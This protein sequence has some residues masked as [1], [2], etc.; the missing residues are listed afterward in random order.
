MDNTLLGS[1]DYIITYSHTAVKVNT[2]LFL[3]ICRQPFVRQNQA[4]NMN[5]S[6][7]RLQVHITGRLYFAMTVQQDIHALRAGRVIFRLG[8]HC[9]V[10]A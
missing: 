6:V 9:D 1:N 4:C 2:S 10:A 7:L 3:N 5:V 8:R